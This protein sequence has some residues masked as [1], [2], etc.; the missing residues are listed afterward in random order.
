MNNYF[1]ITCEHGGNRIPSRYRSLFAGFEHLLPTHRG[2]DA[3][4]LTMARELSR[5]LDAPLVAS[6]TSR[7]LIDLNRSMGHPHLYSEATRRAD[8]KTRAEIVAEYYLPY[9]RE[10]EEWVRKAISKRKRMIHISSHSFTPELNGEVRNAD[11]G[12]LYN[13]AQSGE[14]EFVK[15]WL[16]ALN[17]RAP[18]LRVRRNYP[19]VGR[20]DGLASYFRRRFAPGAYV[21]VELEIN[22]KHVTPGWQWMEIRK[23]VVDALR[24]ALAVDYP[25]GKKGSSRI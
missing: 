5:A 22:Q 17:V 13:P 25:Y 10:A 16:A 4:A 23:A 18:A 1:L 20:A 11:V 7:L 15:A 6:T 9:R 12:L 2:Y 19:Y 24:D 8:A 3:G 21:G 14:V